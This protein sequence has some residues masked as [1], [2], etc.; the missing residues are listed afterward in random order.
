MKRLCQDLTFKSLR[1][2]E[3]DLN[4]NIYFT[5]LQKVLNTCLD[6]LH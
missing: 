1:Q 4:V 5:T 6:I 3:L 2:I